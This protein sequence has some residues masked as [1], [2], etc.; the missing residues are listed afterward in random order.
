MSLHDDIKTAIQATIDAMGD[1]VALSPTSLALAVQ[2]GY[3][4]G[5]IQPHI[6]YTS[7]EHLKAIARRVL[8]GRYEADSE[9]NESHQSELFSGQLQD[10][11]PIQ[12][13]RGEQPIYKLRYALEPHEVEWNVNILRKSARARLE[14][15]DALE[16]WGDDRKQ[17]AA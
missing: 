14:H 13:K 3:A 4:T 5:H 10:R 12:V 1:A 16:A 17:L 15:A 7:L 6:Q 2:R 8:S 9:D 11:Y